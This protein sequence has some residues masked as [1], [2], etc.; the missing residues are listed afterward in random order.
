MPRLGNA[1]MIGEI[2]A[3]VGS[4]GAMPEPMQWEVAGV[5]CRHERHRYVNPDYAWTIEVLTIR[6]RR[7]GRAFELML[8][9]EFWRA[10][11][12]DLRAFKWLKILSGRPADVTAWLAAT[13]E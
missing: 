3:L 5:E 10:G 6:H 11:A 7:P 9:S 8:T 12:V 13:R 1:K 2:E 4:H